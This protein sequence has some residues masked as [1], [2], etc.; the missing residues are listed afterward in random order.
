MTRDGVTVLL[1]LKRYTLSEL[2][3][4]VAKGQQRQGTRRSSNQTLTL[5]GKND[6]DTN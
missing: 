4:R 6:D 3:S 2:T 1:S 5:V